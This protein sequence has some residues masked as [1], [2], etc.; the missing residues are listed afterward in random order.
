[1][2]RLIASIT[3]LCV[4]TGLSGCASTSAH[5]FAN[6]DRSHPSYH[7]DECKRAIRDTEVHDDIKLL[8][9]VASPVALILSA[10]ALLPAIFVANVGLDTV[11]RVDASKMEVHCGG[12]G[13]TTGKIA[14]EVAKGAAFGLATS[15]AGNALG[16]GVLPANTASS[17]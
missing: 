15:A 3:A 2:Q 5:T 9:S 8:R 7:S 11:D 6:L 1:M 10:G 13:Q 14:Q 16:A 17:K 4:A 12:E